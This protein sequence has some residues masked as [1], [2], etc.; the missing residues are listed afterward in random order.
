MAALSSPGLSTTTRKI[1]APVSG[2][3]TACGSGAAAP[4]SVV[5]R[6]SS[7]VRA[8]RAPG[9][10]PQVPNQ[11][12]TSRRNAAARD[13][14]AQVGLERGQPLWSQAAGPLRAQVV[15]DRRRPGQRV[16]AERGEPDQLAAAVPG[17]GG[18][19]GVAELLQP[20]DGLP[21]GLFGDPQQAAH[22]AGRRPVQA[23]RLHREPVGRAHA[24]V[25][26]RGQFGVQGVDERPEPGEQQQGQLEPGAAGFMVCI[27]L[28]C[29]WRRWSWWSGGSSRRGCCPKPRVPK[30]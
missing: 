4:V 7:T 5:T 21:G 9:S 2:A 15:E 30:G 24:G 17:V 16:D 28:P 26:L 25:A 3:M 8:Q 29:R 27:R 10:W 18:T 19:L 11:P 22:L 12:G 20:V 23:D 6:P 1:A 14:R 13:H